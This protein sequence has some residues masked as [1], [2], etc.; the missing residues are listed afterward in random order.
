MSGEFMLSS[1][2]TL[3]TLTGDITDT[4]NYLDL[5]L[6]NIFVC[7]RFSKTPVVKFERGLVIQSK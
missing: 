4:Y 1:K 3:N 5:H 6:R 7:S 2:L